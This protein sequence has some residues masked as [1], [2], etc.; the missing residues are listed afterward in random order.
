MRKQ[1]IN[2]K[3]KWEVRMATKNI[4]LKIRIHF[5]MKWQ[6]TN[7]NESYC[8]S[9]TESHIH[10]DFKRKT[11]QHE[12]GNSS[13]L[14]LHIYE[15]IIEMNPTEIHKKDLRPTLIAPEKKEWSHF[16]HRDWLVLIMIK[17]STRLSHSN[18]NCCP[19]TDQFVLHF[20]FFM[21]LIF[22]RIN[23]QHIYQTNTLSH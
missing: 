10:T 6:N 4:R 9:I 5:P 18:A 19:E 7:A 11:K 8:K 22:K 1:W 2:L 13:S 15:K 17:I 12:H 23:I 3:E 14:N 16:R 20:M 21:C